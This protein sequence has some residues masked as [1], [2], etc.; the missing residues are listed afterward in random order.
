[1]FYFRNNQRDYTCGRDIVIVTKDVKAKNLNCHQP[2]IVNLHP[3]KTFLPDQFHLPWG[4]LVMVYHVVV[5]V[6]SNTDI[7]G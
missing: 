3:R 4:Q 2:S 1:M 6:V 5:P 7:L